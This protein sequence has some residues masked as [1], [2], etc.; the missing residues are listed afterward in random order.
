MGLAVSYQIIVDN[1]K[2]EIECISELGK[3][4]EFLISIPLRLN[5]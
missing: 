5:L 3:G 1:H 2:G 4:S